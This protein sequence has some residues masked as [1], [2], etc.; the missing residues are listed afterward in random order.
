MFQNWYSNM[1]LGLKTTFDIGRVKSAHRLSNP[2]PPPPPQYFKQIFN[3]KKQSANRPLSKHKSLAFAQIFTC[4]TLLPSAVHFGIANWT[5]S[6]A[7]RFP[8]YSLLH[9]WT[10]GYKRTTGQIHW[11][12]D[13][14]RV[15]PVIYASSR[16][17]QYGFHGLIL[18]HRYTHTQ[19]SYFCKY[20]YK[21]TLTN[22]LEP[23]TTQNMRQGSTTASYHILTA[24]WWLKC[25]F[26]THYV[27]PSEQ[28]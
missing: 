15:Q 24:G 1:M 21:Y 18:G 23:L 2:I 4:D 20:A 28:L 10:F 8:W 14:L 22:T 12:I 27:D 7:N 16:H 11:Q 3:F 13:A 9:T 26:A 5:N 25:Q 19:N 17:D 6:V